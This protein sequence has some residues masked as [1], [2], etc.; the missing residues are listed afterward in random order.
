M[1]KTITRLMVLMSSLSFAPFV[2]AD[3]SNG[4]QLFNAT[5]ARCHTSTTGIKT[6]I[7]SMPAILKSGN[8]RQHRF[9]LSDSEIEIIIQYLSSINIQR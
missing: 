7:A 9:T 6:K 8:I 2:I 4:A 5:C 3:N 1:Q